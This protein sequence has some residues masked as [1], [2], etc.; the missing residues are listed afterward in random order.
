MKWI[1][2]FLFL[3]V[4]SIGIAASLETL[5]SI[6]SNNDHGLWLEQN[7]RKKLGSDWI[8]RIHAEERWGADYRQIHFQ[9]YEGFI[10]Y[11]ITKFL[12]K[13]WRSIFETIVIG[14]AY[15][16]S[17]TLQKNTKDEFHWVWF[18]KPMLEM[19]L[20]STLCKWKIRQRLRGEYI[21]YTRKHY[22]NFGAGRYRLEI[23]TPWKFTRW[24][25]NPY[26]WNEWFFRRDSYSK[27]HP[28]G[29]VG[30]WH[31]N[32]FRVG[33]L[34]EFTEN[35]FTAL[36]WQWLTRKQKPGTRPRWFNNYHIGFM[37]EVSF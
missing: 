31:E 28:T 35:L 1:L 36:Y 7:I 25:I 14:P 20:I 34:T 32:R 17:R 19:Q 16:M 37:T 27:N 26:V 21:D 30:G 6:N 29:L 15:N 18:R 13:S 9:E 23:Y 10:F 4:H 5:E 11:D 33:F 12:S 2:F 24:K 8:L 3:T 22:K